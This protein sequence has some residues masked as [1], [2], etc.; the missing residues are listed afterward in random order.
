MLLESKKPELLLVDE[1]K[2]LSKLAQEK[3]FIISSV[4]RHPL[5]QTAYYMQWREPLKSVNK[6]R[7]S[8]GL[9]PL[10][11]EENKRIT[12]TKISKHCVFLAV[13]IF[14]QNAKPEEYINFYDSLPREIKLIINWGGQWTKLKDYGHFELRTPSEGKFFIVKLW[15]IVATEKPKTENDLFA[16]RH[17]IRKSKE[18]AK[19]WG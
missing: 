18:Y 8:L 3:G 14:K 9:P 5:L 15:Q 6:L 13:D 10:T 16:I 12:D 11:E 17:D 7:Q 19:L 4:W 2:E 1:L